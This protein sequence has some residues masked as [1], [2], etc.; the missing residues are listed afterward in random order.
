M[1]KSASGRL[2]RKF[3]MKASDKIEINKKGIPN[4]YG[5]QV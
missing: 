5:E 1:P 2:I 4:Q 3:S